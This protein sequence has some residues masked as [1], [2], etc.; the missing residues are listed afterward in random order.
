MSGS[1]AGSS[2]AWCAVASW[3][4]FGDIKGDTLGGDG[5]EGSPV[6][7]LIPSCHKGAILCHQGAAGQPRIIC[8]GCTRGCLF[9]GP[10]GEASAQPPVPVLPCL[11]VELRHTVTGT[12]QQG[13][14]A[15]L[16][17]PVWQRSLQ[18]GFSSTPP[19]FALYSRAVA[20]RGWG[21]MA[22]L[23]LLPGKGCTPKS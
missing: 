22:K 5:P 18:Q 13:R 17:V 15:A 21:A 11:S 16:P 6:T 9:P 10:E 14:W 8:P 20:Q 4:F 19:G 23:G 2:S 1:A 3:G 7:R 12:G